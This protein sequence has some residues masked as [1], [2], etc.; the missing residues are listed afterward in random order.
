MEAVR[1]ERSRS[2]ALTVW[3]V[4]VVVYR[5]LGTWPNTNE[6]VKAYAAASIGRAISPSTYLHYQGTRGVYSTSY[7]AGHHDY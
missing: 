2:G 3:S 4:A 1:S 6:R 7:G 5:Y